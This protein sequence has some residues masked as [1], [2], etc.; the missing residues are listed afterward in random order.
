MKRKRGNTLLEAVV[1][2]LSAIALVTIIGGLAFVVG[3]LGWQI[4][5]EIY[6]AGGWKGI[7]ITALVINAVVFMLYGI[8]ETSYDSW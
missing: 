1:C 5:K 7:G 3:A 4:V 2:F 8:L 6:S